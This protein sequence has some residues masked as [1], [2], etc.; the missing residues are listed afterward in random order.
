MFQTKCVEEIKTRVLCVDNFV[1]FFRVNRAIYEITWKNVVKPD[2]PQ[3]T[4]NTAH[5][6]FMLDN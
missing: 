1:F 6:H 2:R 3:M 4:Y 5:A